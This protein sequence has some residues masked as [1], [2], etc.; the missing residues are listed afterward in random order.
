MEAVVRVGGFG[1]APF[2]GHEQAALAQEGEPGIA[3]TS[4]ALCAQQGRDVVPHF[5]GAQ[6][7]E[8]GAH[9]PHLLQHLLRPLGRRRL[10][11][12]AL[13]E[14]LPAHAVE[15]ATALHA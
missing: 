14:A 6:A 5:S 10:A 15:L 7:R 8:F 4:D 9:G 3:P 13:V 11:L 12:A 2:F 1:V